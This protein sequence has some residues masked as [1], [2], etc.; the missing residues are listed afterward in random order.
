MESQHH[1]IIVGSAVYPSFGT[2]GKENGRERC[3]IFDRCWCMREMAIRDC[4]AVKRLGHQ[5]S[6]IIVMDEFLGELTSGAES[7]KS[8]F[9]EVAQMFRN[10]KFFENLKGRPEDVTEIKSTLISGSGS[11]NPPNTSTSTTGGVWLL[12]SSN[13]SHRLD[14]PV[15]SLVQR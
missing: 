15:L 8:I 3:L 1:L 6:E 5:K 13:V 4:I 11:L 14:A 7:G 12:F 2:D 9:A 10:K